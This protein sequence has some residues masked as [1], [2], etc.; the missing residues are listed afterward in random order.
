MEQGGNMPKMASAAAAGDSQSKVLSIG[1]SLLGLSA[2]LLVSQSGG[3][4]LDPKLIPTQ[5]TAA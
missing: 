5:M 4:P 1:T 3:A 2:I